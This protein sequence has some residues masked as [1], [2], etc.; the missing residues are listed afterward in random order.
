LSGPDGNTG[1]RAGRATADAGLAVA[2][3]LALWMWL[4]AA[5]FA[6]P[7]PWCLAFAAGA[8]VVA[9]AAGSVLRRKPRFSTPA[10]RVTLGRAVVVACCAAVTAGGWIAG[11]GSGSGGTV[12]VLGT[13]AFLLDAVDGRVARLTGIATAEG[14]RLDSDTDAA[15]V[16]V[17]S[18]AAAAIFGPWPLAIGLMYY[19]FLAAAR[20]R[21]SL[22]VPLPFSTVRK[23]IGATQP[24]AL[25]FAL[26]PG[27]AAWLGAMVLG[28]A[29]GLLAYSFGR[30]VIALERLRRV[31]PAAAAGSPAPFP[32]TPSGASP[33]A[34]AGSGS[35]RA[36][37]GVSRAG[38]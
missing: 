26:M 4:G 21:P 23:V 33:P 29:L 32:R 28:P 11:A 2:T 24:A 10:D 17:L 36:G 27:V 1:T 37:R 34:Q 3:Y 22:K 30:D 20:F 16:L 13:A 5:A 38:S 9:R 18:C 19:V 15:L 35:R 6:D 8:A 12:V 7:A 25:L 31:D 14:S